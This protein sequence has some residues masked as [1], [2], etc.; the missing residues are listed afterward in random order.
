MKKAVL[1]PQYSD[2]NDFTPPEGVEIV[3]IDKVSN[4]LSDET[5]P[6][7]YDAA[8]LDGT[9]PTDTCDHPADHRN[10][11][12]KIFGLGKTRKLILRRTRHKER[13]SLPH[14]PFSAEKVGNHK[15][16]PASICRK[17]FLSVDLAAV[18]HRLATPA[19]EGDA[20]IRPLHAPANRLAAAAARLALAPIDPQARAGIGFVRGAALPC[21]HRSRS[22]RR[23]PP[24]H[25]RQPA[26][27]R[28]QSR[29]AT[30]SSARAQPP[31][32]TD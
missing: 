9:A 18:R 5:C 27:A 16:Q 32:R 14:P 17:Q 19:P 30:C 6:D 3:K 4:L 11:L 29:P 22:R 7:A 26:F 25:W 8:F 13:A 2:T 12:Q 15:P 31:C 20:R 24:A 10:I 1:L 28:R 23:N 21:R